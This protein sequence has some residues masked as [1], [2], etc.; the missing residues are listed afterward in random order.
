MTGDGQTPDAVYAERRERF[1]REAEAL[2]ARWN[3]VANLRLAA[4]LAAVACLGWGIYV[5]NWP[6]VGA[7]VLLLVA[8][9]VLVRHH[10]MLG[11]ARQ[12]AL[13]FVAI[14][15][16]AGA[17]RR[18]DW[19]ALPLRST[20][21]AA[22]EHPYAADLDLFGRASLFHLLYPGG[23]A[24]GEATLRDWLLVAAAPGVA[25]ERQGSVAELAPRID[26]RDDLIASG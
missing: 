1:A 17:R 3:R 25:R 6:L 8:F 26:L 9:L 12:R 24:L 16:E 20:F 18:R 23:T 13:E 14:S 19:E 11:R 2:Q 22:G 10:V 5:R 4:F 21:R 7:G 15:V